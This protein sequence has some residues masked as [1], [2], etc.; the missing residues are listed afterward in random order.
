[1]YCV[2]CLRFRLPTNMHRFLQTYRL[3]RTDTIISLENINLIN[4]S[5]ITHKHNPNL[6]NLI[7]RAGHQEPAD[8]KGKVRS[9]W[10]AKPYSRTGKV[11]VV[12]LNVM[13][14]FYQIQW[15]I[16]VSKVLPLFCD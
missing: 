7:V 10:L 16:S 2:T 3:Y 1:M 15:A 8:S 9:V 11:P 6:I 4:L 12:S 13:R 5:N 14:G